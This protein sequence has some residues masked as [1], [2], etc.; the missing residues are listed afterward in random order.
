LRVTETRDGDVFVEL[1][2][3]AR[4]ANRIGA[5][6]FVSVHADSAE[7]RDA[8]GYTMYVRRS[9]SEGSRLAARAIEETMRDTRLESRG[10]READ[11]R[12][13]VKTDCP[14]VLVE[15]GFLSNYR[16]AALLDNP[17]FQRLLARSI[18]RG[19]REYFRHTAPRP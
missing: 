7:N 14:A 3:R 15:T 2:E 19:I 17:E 16:E 4:I 8:R 9:A 1:E 12:V 5:E 13:L 10:I 11:F 18:A 6:L